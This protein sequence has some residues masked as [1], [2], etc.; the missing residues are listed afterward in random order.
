MI[1]EHGFID[2]AETIGEQAVRLMHEDD[3]AYTQFGKDLQEDALAILGT[4]RHLLTGYEMLHCEK[5]A[6]L[7]DADEIDVAVIERLRNQY[8]R[9]IA[10]WKDGVSA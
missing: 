5:A 7:D 3:A 4:M 2:T 8:S 6:D 10:A 1:T 9:E